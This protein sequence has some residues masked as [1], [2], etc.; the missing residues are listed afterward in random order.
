MRDGGNSH[1]TDTV[2]RLTGRPARSLVSFADENA[3]AWHD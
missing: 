3:A 2:E 1:V